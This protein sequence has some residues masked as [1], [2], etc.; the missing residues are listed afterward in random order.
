MAI[1]AQ[2]VEAIAYQLLK[3][4]ARAENKTEGETDA[5]APGQGIREYILDTYAECLQAA[6]RLSSLRPPVAGA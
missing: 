1:E 6:L 4:I 5:I 2:T 3:D